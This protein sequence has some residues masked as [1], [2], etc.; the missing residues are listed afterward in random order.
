MNGK[1]SWEDVTGNTRGCLSHT[2][3]KFITGIFL[4][5]GKENSSRTN[6]RHTCTSSKN[7]IYINH[8]LYVI[9]FCVVL[10]ELQRALNC[11]VATIVK[12][13]TAV[14]QEADE[15]H[16]ASRTVGPISFCPSPQCQSPQ[17]CCRKALCPALPFS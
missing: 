1:C 3:I 10:G 4:N 8:T 15:V 16:S 17:V 9:T 6:Y 2:G 14:V 13:G 5:L 11:T 7:I 12:R